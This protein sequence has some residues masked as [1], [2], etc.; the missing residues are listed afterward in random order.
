MSKFEDWEKCSKEQTGEM[1]FLIQLMI[2]ALIYIETEPPGC[3]SSY[4]ARETVKIIE[5]DA[6]SP[7]F[8][9]YGY[10]V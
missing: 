5:R 4:V 8:S 9:P 7:W 6:A 3:D 1:P 2:L 10:K